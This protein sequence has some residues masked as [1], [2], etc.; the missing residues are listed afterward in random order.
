[1]PMNTVFPIRFGLQVP[2]GEQLQAA[3]VF[4]EGGLDLTQSIIENR[5]GCAKA[6]INFEVSLT[7]GY[8]R[9]DGFGK[10]STTIVPGQGQLLGVCVF[11]TGKVLAARQDASDATKY[12][13]YY[14]TGTT[15][16]R[17]NPSAQTFT[18]DTHTNTT[19]DN[20]SINTNL[21]VVGQTITAADLP[22]GTT[23][24]SIVSSSSITISQAATGS[25]AGETINTTRPLTYGTGM[26]LQF[27]QYNWTGTNR[28]VIT[29]GVNPAYT[30]DGT[31]MVILS[32]SGS[33]NNPQFS[34]PF[35][36]YMWV[37]G[38][39]TNS[40]AVKFS[41]PLAEGDWTPIDGAGEIVIGDTV[42]GLAE[43]RN[44]LIVFCQHS[45]FKIVF[46][47]FTSTTAGV[48]NTVY[49]PQVQSVT[50]K[51]GCLEGRTIKE[52]DGDLVFLSPDGVRTISGTFNI[53]DTEIASISR[54]I[55]RIVSSINAKVTPCNAV[56]IDQKT[57]YRLYYTST[58]DPEGQCKGIIGG[59]R[60][61]RDGHEA[62][63]WGEL[64]GIKPACTHSGYMNDGHEYVLHGGYDGYVY[65]ENGDYNDFNGSPINEVYMTVP[66]D[67]GD[68]GLRKAIQRVTLYILVEEQGNTQI[69]LNLIYDLNN[70]NIIQPGAYLLNGLG[71]FTATYDSGL[72]YD[73]G[74][75][76]NSQGVSTF[77]QL[78][79]GSGFLAQL[80]LTSTLVPSSYVIQGFYIEYFPAG[81]R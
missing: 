10:Y 60:R 1:M 53:G 43:W 71:G 38:Y 80:E 25:N 57:Q 13:L 52:I 56:V 62:W 15:W 46:V 8:R 66:L 77:R 31:N 54:P 6:L 61:F 47:P 59:I 16:T 78:V 5:P 55:Q 9:I 23:I 64:K 18:G 69:Y 51:I 36:G 30:Y 29:D 74:V 40:G 44:Q 49:L 22:A 45:I 34:Q 63:E 68:Y 12:N 26:V 32:A 48:T 70:A 2:R 81:R 42:T 58:S 79:Q 72:L 39:S 11:F 4:S 7:G 67:L 75:T 65:Q 50:Y 3:E 37:S 28:V 73:S 17:I 24:A 76:Y 33:A 35:N 27:K 14:G 41:A 19:I 20:I 21:L